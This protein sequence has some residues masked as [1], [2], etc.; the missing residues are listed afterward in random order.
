MSNF[1]KLILI[2]AGLVFGL[3]L[4]Y[5]A[6][7][8]SREPAVSKYEVR[9][10]GQR[11][12]RY[13]AMSSTEVIKGE[14]IDEDGIRRTAEYTLVHLWK[15]GGFS[16]YYEHEHD[17]LYNMLMPDSTRWVFE[18]YR[19][20]ITRTH[21]D[22]HGRKIQPIPE[23]YINDLEEFDRRVKN[24]RDRLLLFKGV[25]FEE[26][27][28]TLEFTHR[29]SLHSTLPLEQA[30]G[31][32]LP[33][34]LV[35]KEK[36]G[37]YEWDPDRRDYRLTEETGLNGL[38]IEV[39]KLVVHPEHRGLAGPLLWTAAVQSGIFD[40]AYRFRL[41][42]N[43]VQRI[44]ETVDEDWQRQAEAKYVPVAPGRL[45][46]RPHKEMIPYFLKLG[47]KFD[48][49]RYANLPDKLRTD[50]GRFA[51]SRQMHLEDELMWI[52]REEWLKIPD[53]LVQQ[54]KLGARIYR[55]SQKFNYLE[56]EWAYTGLAGLPLARREE[57]LAT[58]DTRMYNRYRQMFQDAVD[59]RHEAWAIQKKL[60]KEQRAWPFQAGKP[61]TY[62][63]RH[64]LDTRE[65]RKIRQDMSDTIIHANEHGIPLRQALKRFG[66]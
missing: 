12:D 39:N 2:A 42:R 48:R 34:D 22:R 23:A 37:R 65:Q 45:E 28:G 30:K 56:D 10:N 16:D 25:G 49:T 5:S 20:G 29:D 26:L 33:K 50:A 63:F 24:P 62:E 6:R 54:G 4:G 47:F 46:I 27:V 35:R 21:R 38:T 32:R 3:L 41:N 53:R 19:S 59:R 11:P 52:S 66:P 61:P 15:S 13:S 40:H 17:I 14:Y 8:V 43:D 58:R 18:Q 31:I 9:P 1:R 55:D 51:Q 57:L 7:E 36:Y 64:W 60:P 44:G